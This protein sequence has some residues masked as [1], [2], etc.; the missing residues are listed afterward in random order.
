MTRSVLLPR[1]L[2]VA[3]LFSGAALLGVILADASLPL[4]LAFT[5][6]LFL[7]TLLAVWL[8]AGGERRRRLGWVIASGIVTGLVATLIYDVTK[9][10]L[11]Q[12]D[13]SPY[14]PFELMRVS[15]SCSSAMRLLRIRS[16]SPAPRSTS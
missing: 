15:G 8:L 9:F 12:L 16:A 6:S 14:N 2:A 7:A 4:S 5:G 11:S 13:P 10:V 3:A 1:V